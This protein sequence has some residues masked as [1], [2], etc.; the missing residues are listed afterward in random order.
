MALDW[1]KSNSNFSDEQL[2]KGAQ[3]LNTFTSIETHNQSVVLGSVSLDGWQ[4]DQDQQ[5][6]IDENHTI[7]SVVRGLN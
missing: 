6:P 1:F 2:A 3:P 5:H 7:S 4:Y